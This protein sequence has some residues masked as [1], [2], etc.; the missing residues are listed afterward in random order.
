[1]SLQCIIVAEPLLVE[2]LVYQFAAFT[3]KAFFAYGYLCAEAVLAAMIA[4]DFRPGR[5]FTYD[6]IFN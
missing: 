3:T 1:M 5:F 2:D 6:V 4:G